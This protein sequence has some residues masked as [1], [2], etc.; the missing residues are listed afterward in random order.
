MRF[1]LTSLIGISLTLIAVFALIWTVQS[2]RRGQGSPGLAEAQRGGQLVVS[3]RSEPR[4]FNRIVTG[5]QSAELLALI[6]QFDRDRFLPQ[7]PLG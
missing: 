4:S 3:V 5:T 7:S 2:R 1:R 6:T